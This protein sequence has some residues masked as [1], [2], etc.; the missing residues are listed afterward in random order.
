M[1]AG[2]RRLPVRTQ[3][4]DEGSEFTSINRIDRI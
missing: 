2:E 4:D 1:I 3:F